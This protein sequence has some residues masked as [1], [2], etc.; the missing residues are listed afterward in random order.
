MYL[1]CGL[2]DSKSLLFIAKCIQITFHITAGNFTFQICNYY[3]KSLNH[4]IWGLPFSRMVKNNKT[5]ES[6]VKFAST[7]LACAG[8]GY[9][10]YTTRHISKII[11]ASNKMDHLS[12]RCTMIFANIIF[13]LKC[14][15]SFQ[16]SSV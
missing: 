3:V 2:L 10:A 4:Y 9:I 6:I 13:P 11:I 5:F 8:M 12:V 1:F 15:R 14:K 16:L 7:S